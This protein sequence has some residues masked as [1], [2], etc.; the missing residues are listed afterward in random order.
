MID[1][2]FNG[3]TVGRIAIVTSIGAGSLRV[4]TMANI[5]SDPADACICPGEA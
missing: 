5:S 2:L 3:L 4:F 1:K